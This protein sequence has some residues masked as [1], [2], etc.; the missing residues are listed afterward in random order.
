MRKEIEMTYTEAQIYCLKYNGFVKI[1]GDKSLYDKAITF[2][3]H[4]EDGDIE[5]NAVQEL[6]LPN[7]VL[8]EQYDLIYTPCDYN[9]GHINPIVDKEDALTLLAQGNFYKIPHKNPDIV[10]VKNISYIK[11]VEQ[12]N[13]SIK[14][15]VFLKK[16]KARGGIFVDKN[17]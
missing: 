12:D 10:I 9:G 13:S 11:K 14:Y 5:L 7:E 8:E 1:A 2:I 4:N 17:E 16:P 3:R 6:F 15:Q